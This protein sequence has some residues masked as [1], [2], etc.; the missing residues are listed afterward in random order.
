MVKPILGRTLINSVNWKFRMWFPSVAAPLK[1]R[2]C[3]MMNK[4]RI[5]G[6]L[7]NKKRKQTRL[8]SSDETFNGIRPQLEASSRKF[9]TVV[10]GDVCLEFMC[11]QTHNHSV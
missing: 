1:S 8:D 9:K 4:F 3:Q 10:T 11:R 2:I 6:L 7:L 5:M